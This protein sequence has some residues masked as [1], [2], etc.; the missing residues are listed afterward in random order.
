MGDSL[1]IYNS[2]NSKDLIVVEPEAQAIIIY[3]SRNSKD[4]IV[5]GVLKIWDLPI[6]NSRNSKD[7]IVCLYSGVKHS[8]STTVEI[9]K[10]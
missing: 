3:N 4:L 2:R 5:Q 8:K 10:T 7:L 1:V 9:Q 6:Y